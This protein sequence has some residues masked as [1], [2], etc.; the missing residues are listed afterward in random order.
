MNHFT[1]S[2]KRLIKRELKQ[3]RKKNSSSCKQQHLCDEPLMRSFRRRCS[4][5]VKE[6]RTR[7]YILRRC[8]AMLIC[9]TD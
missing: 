5:M 6:H 9:W 3:E 1:S 8:V 4:R 2:K 7:F